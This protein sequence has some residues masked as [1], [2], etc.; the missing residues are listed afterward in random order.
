MA[1]SRVEYSVLI[2][3]A[4]RCSVGVVL[5]DCQLAI[6]LSMLDQLE[7]KRWR[8]SRKSIRTLRDLLPGEQDWILAAAIP[9]FR[10]ALPGHKVDVMTIADPVTELATDLYG[11]IAAELDLINGGGSEV[12][13]SAITFGQ[14]ERTRSGE[15]AI[16]LGPSVRPKTYQRAAGLPWW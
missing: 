12:S 5:N 10:Y 1:L 15:V 14:Y 13:R 2:A 11:K 4:V 3:E 8:R 6:A 16:L 7:G 9:V